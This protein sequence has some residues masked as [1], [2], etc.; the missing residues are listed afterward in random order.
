MIC[1]IRQSKYWHIDGTWYRP[2][3]MV[4]ILIIMFKD[5]ISMIKIPAFYIV[6]RNRTELLYT[7]LFRSIYNIITQNDLYVKFRIYS[8]RL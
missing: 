6:T 4:Q 1:H 3:E 5:I 8:N 7:K 2:P